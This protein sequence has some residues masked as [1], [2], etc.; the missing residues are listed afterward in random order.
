VT[1]SLDRRQ[2]LSRGLVAGAGLAAVG[3]ASG[4]LAACSSSKSTTSTGTTTGGTTGGSASLGSAKFQ[5]SW[6]EDVEFAGEYIADTSGY[7]TSQGLDVSLLAGGGSVNQDSVVASG[8]ALVCISSPDITAPKIL[9]GADLVTIAAQYQKNPFCITS[10]ASNP[11]PNP[12]AMVGKKIG[13]QPTNLSAW[14]SFL[15]A[16]NLTSGTG[17]GQVNTIGNETFDPTPLV[18]QKVDGWFSFITNEPI[19]IAAQG[20]PVTTF[21]LSDYNYPLVSQTIVTQTSSLTSK[22]DE[23]KAL[24]KADIMGWRA[25]LKDPTVGAELAVNTFGKSQKLDIKTQTAQSK[26]QNQLILDARTIK[27]GIFTVPAVMQA[28]TIKTLAL[29]GTSITAAKLFDLS[30]LTEVYQENPDLMTDPTA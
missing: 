17:S 2:F 22:R 1:A 26:A 19:E 28:S 29:G 24:L 10:L 15:K 27:E 7:W 12:Q 21:L 14:N 5:L 18:D 8:K 16:N 6:V 30:L 9:Q 3:G 23:L 20:H 4:L 11:L 13:V 25:S